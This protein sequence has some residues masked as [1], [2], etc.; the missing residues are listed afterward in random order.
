MSASGSSI[1][2]YGD[3][4]SIAGHGERQ[5]SLEQFSTQGAGRG[6]C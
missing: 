2:G 1:F 3:L 5:Q 6:D 4:L